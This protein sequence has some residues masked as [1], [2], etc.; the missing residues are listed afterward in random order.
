MKVFQDLSFAFLPILLND[1]L[2]INGSVEGNH[3]GGSQ[4][5][6]WQHR[7]KGEPARR[8][9]NQALYPAAG[10]LQGHQSSLKLGGLHYF[11]RSGMQRAANRA[12]CLPC[13]LEDGDRE[14]EQ[15]CTCLHATSAVDLTH[16]CQLL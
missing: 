3:Q 6:A 10:A 4:G 11:T 5:S 2:D 8:T 1:V 16:R 15:S 12:K 13:V 9:R 14:K 7:Q